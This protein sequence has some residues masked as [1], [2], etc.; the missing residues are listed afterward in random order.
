M[1]T[2]RMCGAR[3]MDK[4]ELDRH[5]EAMHPNM[6]GKKGGD[7]QGEMKGMKK[8]REPDRDRPID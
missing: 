8:E 5:N 4:G 7:M 1:E 2:C 6:G 3:L